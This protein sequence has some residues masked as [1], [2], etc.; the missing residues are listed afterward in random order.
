MKDTWCRIETKLYTKQS[1]YL[2]VHEL[3]LLFVGRFFGLYLGI[4]AWIGQT[5]FTINLATRLPI[6]AIGGKQAVVFLKDPESLNST[7]SA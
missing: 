2:L 6:S 1:Y 3:T 7:E 4:L 5:S